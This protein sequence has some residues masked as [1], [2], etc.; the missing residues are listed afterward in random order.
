VDIKAAIL[1]E[2]DAAVAIIAG[3]DICSEILTING[4]SEDTSCCGFAHSTRPTEEK[5]VR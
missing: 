3:L 4:L 1:I 5:R 2:R